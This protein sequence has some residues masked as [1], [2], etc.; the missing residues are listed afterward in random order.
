ML[1]KIFTFYDNIK[2]SLIKPFKGK[3]G[4]KLQTDYKN[5]IFTLPPLNPLNIIILFEYVTPQSYF[6]IFNVFSIRK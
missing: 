3:F 4:Y 6:F 1:V 5:D 2:I